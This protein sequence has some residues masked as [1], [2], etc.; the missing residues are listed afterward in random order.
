[1]STPPPLLIIASLRRKALAFVL[2]VLAGVALLL[3]AIA[4]RQGYFEHFNEI[5][6][7][8]DSATGISRGMPVKLRG[9]MVG[10]VK[11]FRL[12]SGQAPEE[13]SIAVILSLNQRYTQHVPNTSKVTLMQEGFIGQSYIEILPGE[14]SRFVASGESLQFERRRGLKE[15]IDELGK[16]AAP[17]LQDVRQIAHRL[18]DPQ[19]ELHTSLKNAANLAGQLPD[20]GRQAQTSLQSARTAFEALKDTSSAARTQIDAGVPPLLDKAGGVLD[21]L[22]DSSNTVR[23][24][25][26]DLRGPLR[27]ISEDGRQASGDARLLLDGV[28]QSWPARVL[29]GEPARQG[30]LPD[31]SAG[32]G[33]LHPQVDGAEKP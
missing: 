4:W 30:V 22:Q 10:Q 13:V 7:V 8:V 15:V 21:A 9:V 1:M 14:G 23:Q 3:A 27:A 26:A 25:T 6:F 24:L 2:P 5:S 28:K 33:I 31:S 16:E 20:I 32:S 17:I 18:A 11:D 19:G 12:T 29:F